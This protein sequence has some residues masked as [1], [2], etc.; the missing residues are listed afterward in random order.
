MHFWLEN[1]REDYLTWLAIDRQIMLTILEDK[2][3]EDVWL[4]DL[5]EN[6]MHW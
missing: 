1:I 4:I 5:D 2:A 3:F 6:S